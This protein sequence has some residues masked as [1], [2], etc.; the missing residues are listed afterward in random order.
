MNNAI[1]ICERLIEQFTIHHPD[2]TLSIGIACSTPDAPLD[3]DELIHVADNK[4]Y[5]SKQIK[6][7]HIQF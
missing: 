3:Q 4:M 1:A 2:I 7:H 6:G 5:K